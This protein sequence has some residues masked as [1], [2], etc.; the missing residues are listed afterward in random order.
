MNRTQP[1]AVDL[2]IVAAM[3]FLWACV[4][5][6]RLVVVPL[7]ALLVALLTPRRQAQAQA[8]LQQ[9]VKAERGGDR[10]SKKTKRHAVA[11]DP[12]TPANGHPKDRKSR[13]IRTLTLSDLAADLMA[14]PAKRLME[15]AGTRR[16][17]PKAQLVA[18]I[19]AMPI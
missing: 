18:M 9:A 8:Q 5:V 2:L 19:C 3:A 12:T 13:L 16:R 15:L 1:C 14:L 17:L 4:T 7:L 11:N 10:R 6:V